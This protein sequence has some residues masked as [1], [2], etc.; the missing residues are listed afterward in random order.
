M[1]VSYPNMGLYGFDTAMFLSHVFS[2]PEGLAD[3]APLYK[4]IQT[5]FKFRRA[6]PQ[7]GL[8]NQ[9]I[10]ITHFSPDHKIERTSR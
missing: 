1:L 7:S 2:Q 8:V 3:D 6:T 9:A 10:D 5:S 4:G